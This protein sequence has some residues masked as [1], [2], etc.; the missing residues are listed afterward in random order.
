M[1]AHKKLLCILLTLLLLL[2]LAACAGEAAPTAENT[3]GSSAVKEAPTAARTE[4]PAETTAETAAGTTAEANAEPSTGEMPAA[5]TEPSAE[6]PTEPS[7]EPSTEAP[8][9]PSDEPSTE[10]PS[11]EAPPAEPEDPLDFDSSAE[12]KRFLTGAWSFFPTEEDAVDTPVIDGTPG[13]TIELMEDGSF[14]AVRGAD[15]AKFRGTWKLD[16]F[17]ADES[18]LPDRISFTLKD[19]SKPDAFGSYW[20]RGWASCAETDRLELVNVSSD[21]DLFATYPELYEAMLVKGSPDPDA[22]GEAPLCDAQF[23]GRVWQVSGNGS[24][25]WITEISPENFSVSL[26][27]HIA[28]RYAVAADAELVWPVSVFAGGG[29]PAVVKT[30]AA[31]E[32]IYL[33]WAEEAEGN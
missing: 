17:F 15:K 33:D 26:G 29:C 5:A 13:V 23:C 14:R 24:A 3:A 19:T 4:A 21:A 27:S 28:A 2:S 22:K 1:K 18:A 11:T 25:L 6:A 32:I 16:H 8:T 10:V 7:A 9:E 30:N 31:G 12:L 20:I